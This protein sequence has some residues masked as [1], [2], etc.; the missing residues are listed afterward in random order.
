MDTIL[1]RIARLEQSC[2]AVDYDYSRTQCTGECSDYCRCTRIYDAHVTQ[3][4][5]DAIVDSLKLDPQTILGYCIER[6]FHILK[7]W[8]KDAWYVS[9]QP[10]YYGEEIGGCSLDAPVAHK[11]MSHAKELI[12]LKDNKR[13]EKVLIL[14]YGFLLEAAKKRKWSIEKLERK[15]VRVGQETYYR[16]IDASFVY[17]QNK[18]PV[19]VCLCEGDDQFRLIDG[20]HRFS[21]SESETVPM[22]VG[23]DIY[24][25]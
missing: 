1:K 23:H 17:P 24:R 21:A 25:H 11:L 18:F 2:F 3:I 9:V 4:D 19:G 16:K 15:T 8:Q 5:L 14:E 10:G 12:D 20:Y 7:V 6:L 13:V 22:I